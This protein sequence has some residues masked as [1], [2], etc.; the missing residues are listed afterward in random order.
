MTVQELKDL[1]N[2][3]LENLDDYDSDKEVD[4]VSNTYFLGHPMHFLGIA[5]SKGGYISLD[6]PVK[7]EDEEDWQKQNWWRKPPFLFT[8]A[9]AR[10]GDP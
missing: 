4:M 1:L 10:I 6:S 9:Q 2:Q 7:E 5:G 3:I 8:P